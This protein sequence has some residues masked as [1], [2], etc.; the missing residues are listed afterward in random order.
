MAI[1]LTPCARE[2]VRPFLSSLPL[3]R[4]ERATVLRGEPFP[5]NLALSPGE[6][7]ACN[8]SKKEVA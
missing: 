8:R 4:D 7:R 5:L 2:L 3:L 1:G 6:G